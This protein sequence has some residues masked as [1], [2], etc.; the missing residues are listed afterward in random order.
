MK[1]LSPARKKYLFDSITLSYPYVKYEIYDSLDNVQALFGKNGKNISD[2]T[3]QSGRFNLVIE[4]ARYVK[5]LSR[6]FFMSD[7]QIG[8]LGIFN[9][10]FVFNDY[11]TSEKFSIR[12]SPLTILAD[13]VDRRNKRVG[14]KLNSEIKP[15]GSADFYISI[16]PKD[17]G[18]FDMK[19]NIE[20]IPA[21]TFNPYLI[22]LTSFRW[23]GGH[24]S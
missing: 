9:G 2:I 5:T 23:T 20:K 12:A 10:D 4:I 13:S 16:N 11:S 6:N 14:L 19:Y 17:S 24:W 7:F 3:N 8:T 1:N 21:A 15:F 22:S 18:D